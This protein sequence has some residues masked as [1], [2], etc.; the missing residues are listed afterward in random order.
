MTDAVDGDS[1]P[2]GTTDPESLPMFPL[3]TVLMPTGLL[4]LRLFEPRYLRFIEDVLAAG[5]GFGV[6]LIERGS[7]VG[8]GDQRCMIGCRAVVHRADQAPDGTW[9]VL[10][11]GTERI[12]VVDWLADDPYPRALVRPLPDRSSPV[13]ADDDPRWLELDTSFRHLVRL[14]SERTGRGPIEE[15]ELADDPALA[16]FQMA[17]VLPLNPFDRQRILASCDVDERRRILLECF[18]DL[19]VLVS[20]EENH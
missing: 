6:V 2:I 12:E 17:A 18:E 8:G 3:G 20:G 16:T 5:H 14:V 4:P 15:I 10:A 11:I 1:D 9:Q 19:A 13:A 7:E